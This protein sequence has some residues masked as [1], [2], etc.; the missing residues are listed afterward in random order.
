MSNLR[1]AYVDLAAIRH[2]VKVLQNL[3]KN[4]EVMAVVKADA[5]GHGLI[6]V[7]RAARQ[8]G[9]T[10]LGTALLE[11]AISLRN[12]GDSGR[13]LTWL[14]SPNDKWQECIDLGIDISVSSIEIASGVIKAAKKIGKKAKIHIK[15]DTG[16]G[17]NGVMP[18]D[19]ADL[20]SLLEEATANGLVEVV[21]VWTHFA[22][23]DAPSSPTIAKQLEVLDASFKFVESRG[24]KNL[25]KHAANSAATL[26]SPHTHFDLVRPGIAVYGI[27][28]G[29]EVGKASE[30]GLRPAMTLKAQA[31]LVKD[32]P[33]GHGISY[34]AEYVTKQNTKIALIPLGYADG[35]PRIAGNK[36]PVLA[37]GKKFSVAG[38]VCMD[39]FVIDIGDLDFSTGDEVILFGDPAQNE[40]DVEEWAKASQSIGYEI[41]TRLGSRVPRIYLNEI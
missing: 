30:Y 26:T 5:Y 17:R 36:G 27:T 15:V 16:L 39:Q 24:F 23:A 29:G 12:S 2:N 37:N 20:T 19:L 1:G 13:I 34:G 6:P 40:P 38:R 31:A 22:L 8:G 25:M 10:W 7:A 18:N 41:V 4:S 9:A 3:A 21:A 11:E 14:G 35:I 28:P 32:V 33:A